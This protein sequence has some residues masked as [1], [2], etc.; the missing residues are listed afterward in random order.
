MSNKFKIPLKITAFVAIFYVLCLAVAFLLRDDS[1]S[2]TRLL[3]HELYE[4]DNIDILY[5]GAS[6]VSH[7][8]T[9]KVA[10]RMSG[11]NNFSS[12]TPSQSIKGTYAILRQATK[13]YDIEKVFLE[14]DF[15]VATQAAAKYR[16]GFTADYLIAQYIR[17]PAI[18]W[19][20]LFSVTSPK[21]YVNTILPIGK[22]K[23]MTLNPQS[24][25]LRAKSIF[26]GSYFRYEYVEDGFEYD[27][28]GCV[29]DLEPVRNGTFFDYK[30]K[31]RILV[32]AVSDDWKN[33]VDDI[34]ALC[35][36]KG[37]E[38]IFYSQPCSDFYLHEKG[39]YDEYYDF[40]KEFT[41]SRGFDYYD[42][43]LAKEKYQ[44]L[45]DED[46]RDNNHFSKQ[47]V[48]KWTKI[49]CD[50]F[51]TGA[52][53]K[54]DM[55][56]TSYA[57]KI[58]AQE[59]RIYGLHMLASNDK[60]SMTIRPIVNHV[61]ESRITYDVLIDDGNGETLLAERTFDTKIQ[62]PAGKSGTVRVVSYLDGA[63]Q[64][65]CK[66]HFTSF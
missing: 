19:S 20:Y 15:A 56:H 29:L 12:G 58:A 57:E 1:G 51:F 63:R 31:G 43:N 10:D 23:Q 61:D 50:Y 13:L 55:F 32:E 47:G 28:K 46:F 14:I 38:L 34:I 3:M 33:T 24:L 53:P 45:E 39:N 62:L 64:N 35:K 37:I 4:Q 25:F 40:C 22:D 49:F 16:S 48:Y 11:R 41:S 9:A 27:G 42:F 59:D 44:K 7:G 30:E 8:I 17:D 54:D 2:Y 6:H 66:T 60:K 65:D 5:C 18:K 26:D 21:Y 52:I 36:E